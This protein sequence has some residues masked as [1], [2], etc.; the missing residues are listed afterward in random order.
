MFL[1]LGRY[2]KCPCHLSQ[3]SPWHC[4]ERKCSEW[5]GDGGKPTGP[6]RQ[7][8]LHD[9]SH[10]DLTWVF[11]RRRLKSMY[12]YPITFFF[13]EG[14]FEF[15]DVSI[16]QSTV[17]FLGKAQQPMDGGHFLSSNKGLASSYPRPSPGGDRIFCPHHYG[18]LSPKDIWMY[19]RLCLSS[20]FLLFYIHSASQPPW[21][22]SYGRNNSWL[23]CF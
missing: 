16:F 17:S 21:K 1:K 18:H 23:E 8:W 12:N 7:E 14:S 2:P 19:C 11:I 22:T 10:W 5:L 6:E 20:P 9:E 4:S 13:P 15:D 3:E